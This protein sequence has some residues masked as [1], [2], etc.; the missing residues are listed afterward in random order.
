MS[1][2]RTC[3]HSDC[4]AHA[5]H[6]VDLFGQDFH[7]CGHHWREIEQALLAK[8]PGATV[9]SALDTLSRGPALTGTSR[10]RP[11]SYR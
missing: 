2:P 11:G 7:F 10:G 3:D 9:S 5:L 6:H 1:A 4:P 8:S